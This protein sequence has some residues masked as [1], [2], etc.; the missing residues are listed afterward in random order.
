MTTVVLAH[1]QLESLPPPLTPVRVGT[2][3]DF[4]L[5]LALTIVV[6]AGLYLY[7]V[8]RLRT[9]GDAWSRWRTCCFIGL[10]LGAV[11]LATSSALAVYDTTLL[12]VHMVQHM[13]LTM[14]APVFLALG[15]PITL[16][17]R[18]LPAR[19]RWWLLASIHSRFARVLTFPVLAGA[20]FVANPFMLYFTGWY[21]A[22]LRNELLH[23]VNHVHFLLTGCLW[24]WP[25][26]GLDPMPTRFAY[27]LRMIAV[28]AT[29]PFHAWLGVAVMSSSTL[30]AGDWYTSLGREWGPSLL[31]DQRTAGGILWTSG[32]VVGVVLLAVLFVQWSRAAEREA[33][34]EDRR[35]DR[36]EARG[37]IAASGH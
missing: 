17:L 22:T 34:R 2:E 13:V 7:G 15:A 28:F 25:L 4:E 20:A 6:V 31:S 21:E 12:S 35:L 3:W 16:A 32:D 14:V 19:P 29:L 30:I 18:T 27:P 8:S 1:A 5:W 10:G 24:F 33:A 23:H 36:L 26:L 37:S 9:R 11:V